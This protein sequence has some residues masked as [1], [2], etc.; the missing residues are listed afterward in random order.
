MEAA[1]S[2]EAKRDHRMDKKTN[3][4]MIWALAE[5][6]GEISAGASVLHC[7]YWYHDGKTLICHN[8]VAPYLL[9]CC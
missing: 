1:E 8:C 9:F 7:D 2:E 5:L 4:S 3:K 6:V